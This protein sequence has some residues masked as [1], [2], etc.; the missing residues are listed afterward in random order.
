MKSLILSFYFIFSDAQSTFCSVYM[1]FLLECVD[2]QKSWHQKYIYKKIKLTCKQVESQRAHRI[3]SKRCFIINYDDGC[4]GIY[5][6]NA[7]IVSSKRT[8]QFRKKSYVQ[9]ML[10]QSYKKESEK[11]VYMFEVYKQVRYI[12]LVYV[13]WARSVL[14]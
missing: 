6:N 10:F 11:W 3:M 8:V 14:M 1:R 2:V 12:I 4:K 7:C 9:Y 5:K 13:T